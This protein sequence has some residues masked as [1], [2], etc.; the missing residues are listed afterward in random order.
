MILYGLR[1]SKDF[2]KMDIVSN[3]LATVAANISGDIEKKKDP[4][5]AIIKGIDQFWDVSLSKFIQEIVDESAYN[6]QLPD[7]MRNSSVRVGSGGFPV[8]TRD[9]LGIPVIARNEIEILFKL[10]EKGEIDPFNLKQELDR[11]GMFEQYQD[12]FFRY[13]R[14]GIGR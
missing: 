12:R 3:S 8:I 11:W 1:L 7:L 13:F 9:N 6:S 14:K 5:S 4:Y 2:E 10:F